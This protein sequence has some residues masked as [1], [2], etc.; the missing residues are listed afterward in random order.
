MIGHATRLSVSAVITSKKPDII[1]KIFQLWISVYGLHEQF[2]NLL[3][4][5]VANLPMTTS[6]TCA[7]Q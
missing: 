6:P 1:S 2:V 7:K 4:T 3:V 5:T